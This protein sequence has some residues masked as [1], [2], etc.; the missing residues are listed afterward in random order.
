MQFNPVYLYSNKLDVFTS[1]ADT[2]STER[3]RKVYNRNLKIYRGVDNRIDIQVR[4]ADQKASNITGSTLVFNLISKETKNL[5]LSKDFSAMD[6]ATGKVTVILTDTE[7]LDLDNGFYHYS[8]IKE[9]RSDIDSTDYKVTSKLPLYVDS[10]Y[11]TIG[12]LEISG[13]VYGNVN[14]SLVVDTFRYTNPFATG[15]VEKPWF[16][17]AIIDASPKI[18]TG[19]PL[20]TFQF[21]STNYTG[22]V[23]IQ[24][25]LDDQGGTPRQNSWVSIATVDLSTESYKNVVGHWNWFRIRHVPLKSSNTAQFTV[26]QTLLLNYQVSVYLAGSGYQIGDIITIK[27]NELGGESTTNDLTITV[28]N[29][30]GIGGITGISWAGISYNGVKTFVLSGSTNGV[31]TIDKVLYR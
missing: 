19:D 10:Q 4:N 31:G 13:D 17:S 20:H 30:N 15:S 5:V 7:L 18:K 23:T 22:T 16:E 14:S 9:V 25:S 11:D 27:G 8:I 26:G 1:P 12:T 2:W 28:T 6:L 29:V 21:Y 24:G 3:Y